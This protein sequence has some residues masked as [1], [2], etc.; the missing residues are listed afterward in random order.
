MTYYAQIDSHNK[1]IDFDKSKLTIDEYGSIEVLNI[2]VS[3]EVYNN[4]K[5]YG[6]NYYIY[7][8][9]EI[10]VNPNY[11]QEQA[12]KERERINMLYLTAADVERAIYKDKG[13]DFEDI[14]AMLD[15]YPEID[16]KAVR[17]EF[18]A[19]NFYRGNPYV[20]QIG[21]LLEYTSEQLDYLFEHK[22]FPPHQA[23][24]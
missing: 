21:A 14:L 4:A 11:A 23:E 20:I 6:S 8:D 13:L 18:K 17:I 2:E 16:K 5:Q 12:A 24:V 7:S 19:N 10:I 9:E 1:L 22:E 3:E 15:N